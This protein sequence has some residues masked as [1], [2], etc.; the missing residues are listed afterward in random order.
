[1]LDPRCVFEINV[2]TIP[3]TDEVSMKDQD[4]TKEQLI[5]ELEATRR[6]LKEFD[7]RELRRNA[8][9][10]AISAIEQKLAAGVQ[11]N[12]IGSWACNIETHE[13]TLKFGGPR[14]SALEQQESQLRGTWKSIVHPEH[15]SEVLTW[16]KSVIEEEPSSDFTWFFTKNDKL[17]I[18]VRGGVKRSDEST[19]VTLGGPLLDCT[20]LMKL[21]PDGMYP[22]AEDSVEVALLHCLCHKVSAEAT[23]TAYREASDRLI[24]TYE[25]NRVQSQGSE[26]RD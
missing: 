12:P 10:K 22:N 9:T 26:S 7:E 6:K 15:L 14:N 5:A 16:W 24:A 11:K 1:M 13:L 23:M 21:L 4:K 2:Q 8:L 18:L 20:Q 3:G 25:D 17:L 19:E